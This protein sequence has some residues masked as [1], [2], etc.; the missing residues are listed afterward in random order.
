MTSRWL[1]HD[2]H[3]GD[4]PVASGDGPV[5]ADSAGSEH[6]DGPGAGGGEERELAFRAER[7][8]GDEVPAVVEQPRVPGAHRGAVMYDCSLHHGLAVDVDSGQGRLRAAARRC[9]ASVAHPAAPSSIGTPTS[10]PYSVH[11]PS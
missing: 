3:L 8:L 1:D 11:E 5:D 10:E 6:P 9:A 2:V 4:P 7:H